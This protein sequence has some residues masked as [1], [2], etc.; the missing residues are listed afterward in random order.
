[1]FLLSADCS[2]GGKFFLQPLDKT[3]NFP[4]QKF[5]LITDHF[6]LLKVQKS[7][8]E[9]SKSIECQSVRMFILQGVC[10]NQLNQFFVS[11]FVKLQK[12]VF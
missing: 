12:V 11:N 7:K 1:M 9:V 10:L 6:L 2:P 3:K 8:T 4:K 5:K